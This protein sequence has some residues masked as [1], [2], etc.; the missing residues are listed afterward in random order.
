MQRPTWTFGVSVQPV[1][2]ERRAAHRSRVGR[3]RDAYR[4]VAAAL[5]IA[6]LTWS[7]RAHAGG[8]GLEGL[9][10]LVYVAVAIVAVDI[11]FTAYDTVQ[12]A[13]GKLPDRTYSIVETLM[14]A[15]QIPLGAAMYSSLAPDDKPIGAALTAWTGA[16]TLHGIWGWSIPRTSS[17]SPTTVSRGALSVGPLSSP[18]RAHVWGIGVGTHF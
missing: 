11:G 5:V 9:Q 16:M 14:T 2:C 4:W 12:A 7:P 15:P 13:R 3:F 1:R 10:A 6:S 8:T 18:S 17:A